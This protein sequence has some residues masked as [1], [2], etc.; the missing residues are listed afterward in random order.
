MLLEYQKDDAIVYLLDE[1]RVVVVPKR[2][3]VKRFLGPFDLS[4]KQEFQYRRPWIYIHIPN[5]IVDSLL[6]LFP[7]D[8]REIIEFGEVQRPS[9]FR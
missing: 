5:V 6:S 7:K 9:I 3:G 8:M 2:S 4:K 1:K